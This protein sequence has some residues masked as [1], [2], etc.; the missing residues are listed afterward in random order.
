MLTEGRSEKYMKKLLGRTNIEDSLKRLDKLTQEEARMATAQ[1]LKVTHTI[2]EGVRGVA[3]KV[4]GVDDRVASVDER[5]AGVDRRVEGVDSRVA[6]VNNKL[7]AIGD[8]VT[9]VD[10]RVADVGDRVRTVDNKIA[11]V[12]E[13]AQII[14]SQPSNGSFNP[15][16]PDGK[17]AR[18]AMQQA[19]S[20]VDQMKRWSSLNNIDII[21]AGS[22]VLTGNQL[23]QDLRRW[24]SPPD[25]STSHNVAC[26]AHHEGTA[27]WF[28]QGRIFEEW[29]TTDSLLWVHGKRMFST[30]SPND[31]T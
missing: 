20:D 2:D 11:V 27:A 3:D 17:E 18:V 1:V 16:L 13:G 10:D 31:P 21:H 7:E 30:A 28:F 29:K 6:G 5:V 26:S 8:R 22:T 14:F 9:S 25:P 19:A 24:L 23:R 15:Y 12:I 4:V